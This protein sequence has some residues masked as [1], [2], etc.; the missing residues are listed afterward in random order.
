MRVS[1]LVVLVTVGCTGSIGDA[2]L[3]DRPDD[4]DDPRERPIEGPPGAEDLRRLTA[5][6][7]ETTLRDLFGDAV[8]DNASDALDTHPNDE[9]D[10]GFSSM[11]QEISAGHVDAHVAV[12]DAVAAALVADSAAREA[13]APCLSNLADQ[14]CIENFIE[15]F[16]RRVYRHALNP[17]QSTNLVDAYLDGASITPEDGF[18]NLIVSMLIAPEF[19]YRLELEGEAT[20]EEDTITLTDVEVATRLAYALWGSTPDADLLDAAESGALSTEEGYATEVDRLLADPRAEVQIGR[21]FREWLGFGSLPEVQQPDEFLAGVERDGLTDSMQAELEWLV[22]NHVFDLESAYTDLLTSPLANPDDRLA[23]V[24]GATTT[25]PQDLDPSTRGG[26]LTRAGMLVGATV[27]TSPVHRGV[28]ALEKL[29]CRELAP[30]DPGEVGAPIEPPPFD[31]DRTARER[32]DDKTQ[33]PECSSCHAVINP[34][35]FAFEGYDT[36]GRFRTTEPVRDPDTDEVVNELPVDDAVD[37]Q[38]SE[39][40]TSIDGAVGFGEALA[41]SDDGQFCFAEQWFRYIRARHP[42]AGGD[43]RVIRSLADLSHEGRS[44]R[45]VFRELVMSE[46]FRQRTIDVTGEEE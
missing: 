19:I 15:G 41:A 35:G 10:H 6:E 30:P 42:S 37:L 17:E 13:L 32:W 29:L 20:D 14:P 31:P 22:N 43:Y 25:G 23:P 11:A 27:D 38:L 26:L 5:Q 33:G 3:V 9:V 18:I 2:G 28:V 21:F 16:G 24:Y 39:G 46:E 12:A 40:S 4:P 8:I 36:L 7:Y 34:L 1:C 44:M 45:W